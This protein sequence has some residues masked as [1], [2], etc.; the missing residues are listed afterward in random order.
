MSVNASSKEISTNI[1][2][3]PATCSVPE[4]RN[5]EVNKITMPFSLDYI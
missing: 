3:A 5:A 1:H 2:G 4:P